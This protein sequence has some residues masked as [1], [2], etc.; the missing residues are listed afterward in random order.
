M[1]SF[2]T[3]D[4]GSHLQDRCHTVISAKLRGRVTL[5]QHLQDAFVPGDSKSTAESKLWKVSCSFCLLLMSW[6]ARNFGLRGAEIEKQ[7]HK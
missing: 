2:V 5:Q 6:H 1:H 4:V 3:Q 7:P